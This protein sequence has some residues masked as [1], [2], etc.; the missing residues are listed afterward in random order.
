MQWFNYSD[1]LVL[2]FGCLAM[3]FVITVF[4]V[5]SIFEDHKLSRKN[6][7]FSLPNPNSTLKFDRGLLL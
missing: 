4:F 3:N 7:D 5:F 1:R 6:Q 2:S